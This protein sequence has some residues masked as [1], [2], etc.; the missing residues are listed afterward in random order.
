MEP[1]DGYGPVTTSWLA[2][3]HQWLRELVQRFQAG[4][5][6]VTG[7]WARVAHEWKSR[8]AH[9]PCSTEREQ[10]LE[11]ITEGG[12]LPFHP[13]PSAPMRN[14]RN[15][16]NLLQK[17]VEVWA[18]VEEQLA[19]GAVVPFDVQG[20][21]SVR[22]MSLYTVPICI[23]YLIHCIEPP[24]LYSTEKYR[25]ECVYGGFCIQQCIL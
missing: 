22:N 10:L 6:K 15:N 3:A 8:F 9:I 12:K 7:N 19:E 21:T 25:I 24:T 11:I 17:P 16:P 2:R 18:T 1:G 23:E 20:A 5:G 13:V 14:F 4:D